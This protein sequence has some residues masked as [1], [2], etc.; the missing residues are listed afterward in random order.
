M[1]AVP[2][3]TASSNEDVVLWKGTTGEEQWGLWDVSANGSAEGEELSQPQVR[4]DSLY[5]SFYIH[6]HQCLALARRT[7][8]A[9]INSIDPANLSTL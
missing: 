9:R 2:C 3:L 8:H 7:L 4:Q 1:N 6:I 5:C